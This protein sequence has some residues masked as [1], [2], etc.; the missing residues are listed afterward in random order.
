MVTPLVVLMALPSETNTSWFERTILSLDHHNYDY[1]VMPSTPKQSNVVGANASET[2]RAMHLNLR[3]PNE[4]QRGCW[5]SHLRAWSYQQML[6]RP[7]LSLEADTYATGPWDRVASSVW[8][9]YD[10]LFAHSHT[11]R[12]TSCK[13]ETIQH[14]MNARYGAGA[15]LFTGR[16]PLFDVI[17]MIDTDLPIDHWLNMVTDKKLL[18]VATLCPSLFHQADDKPSMIGEK[19]KSTWSRLRF[20]LHN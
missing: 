18:R 17:H 12:H 3:H 8:K 6:Q 7:I 20:L 16:T 13:K 4:G 14:G 5:V 9:E 10:I 1:V 2:I 11:A 15:M 19:S